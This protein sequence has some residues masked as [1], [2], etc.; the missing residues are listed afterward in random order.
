MRSTI[1][2]ST[3]GTPAPG[4]R[5]HPHHAVR[6]LAEQ[7]AELAS[8]AVGIR[9]RQVDLVHGRDDLEAAV[10][11]EVGV[12]ERLR[13]D[14]LRGVDDQERSFARLQRARHLVR[15]VHVARRVDEVELVAA[16]AHAHGLRLDRDAALALELHRVEQLLAHLA[17]GHRAGQ[18][19]DAVGERRLA[20]VDVRDDREVA[21][22]V[23]LK[24]CSAL[25]GGIVA[26]GSQQ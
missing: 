18:L 26:P 16:P 12:R 19:E 3:S 21:N 22:A 7:V 6:R 24:V 2:S 1:A 15:E 5:G 23:L 17:L 4:L 13:L 14:P 11:R 20:V 25:L 10:D 9:L 8:G